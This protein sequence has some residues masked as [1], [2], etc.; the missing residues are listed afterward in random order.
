MDSPAVPKPLGTDEEDVAWALATAEA[1]WARGDR[2]DA[3]KWIRKAAEAASEADDILRAADLASAAADLANALDP[4]LAGPPAGRAALNKTMQSHQSLVPGLGHGA[5]QGPAGVPPAKAAPP[6]PVRPAPVEVRRPSPATGILSIKNI[7]QRPAPAAAGASPNAASPR[8]AVTAPRAAAVQVT[9]AAGQRMAPLTSARKP[10]PHPDATME[11]PALDPN[12]TRALETRQSSPPPR[13]SNRPPAASPSSPAPKLAPPSNAPP[14]ADGWDLPH[15]VVLPPTRTAL[16]TPPEHVDPNQLG[17]VMP[18][19]GATTP[20]SGRVGPIRAK[21]NTMTEVDREV[22]PEVGRRAARLQASQ[23]FHVVLWKDARGVHV[24]PSGTVVSAIT[25]DAI[26]IALDPS[27][28]LSAWL[29]PAGPGGP[30]GST[31]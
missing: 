31:E 21:V 22:P 14:P 23:A 18:Y 3:I 1:M 6:V 29:Q 4:A 12:A 28:D 17:A 2:L 20:A 19:P 26:L 30:A 25:V 10:D 24:A 15:T 8:P 7:H 5:G 16:E 27:A 13:P 11:L 9:P